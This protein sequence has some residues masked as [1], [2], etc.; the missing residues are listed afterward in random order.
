M[1]I[2][3]I[4]EK[5]MQ[6]EFKKKFSSTH[7]YNFETGYHFDPDI[8]NDIDIV[9]DWLID[10]SL[11]NFELYQDLDHLTVFCHAPKIS[12]AEIAFFHGNPSCTVFGFNGLP[13]MVN[14]PSLEVSLLKP[15]DADHL[16]KLANALE[17]DYFLVEDRV[18]MF[19]PRLM[20][21][22][23]NEAYF[24]MQ[25]GLSDYNELENKLDSP[26][27]PFEILRTIGLKNIYEILEAMYEDTKDDRYRICPKLKREYLF[28]E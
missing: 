17:T 25:E 21:V 22:Q 4:A 5:E 23:V 9:F 26:S 6:E 14:K 20:A 18:G 24:A 13:T 2:L 28:S 3:V 15:T 7:K 11:E 27:N 1:K 12:L 8:L 10:E 19:N 16:E